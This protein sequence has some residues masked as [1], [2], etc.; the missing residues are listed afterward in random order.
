MEEALFRVWNQYVN[1]D[2]YR[3]TS[4][5]Y[6]PEIK[7]EGLDPKKD[8]FKEKYLEIE[9]LFQI[10]TQLEEKG[11]TYQERWRDGPIT[12]SGII[13]FN[14]TSINNDY[15]DFVADYEQALKFYQR[16]RGGA[17][18]TVV[19]NFTSFLAD[20]KMSTTEKD[21][22]ERLHQWSEEKRSYPNHIITV[23]ASHPAFESA[24][25]L[26]LPKKGQRTTVASP[27]GSFDHF[28]E[29]VKDRIEVYLPYLKGE[30][31]SYLRVGQR[32][33][34]ECIKLFF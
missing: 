15:L 16:W 4:E 33:G 29:E 27:Y 9:Q 31:L 30:E 25:M 13:R 3:V 17:L 24:Q 21:L 26:C 22:V 23:N 34:P 1:R 2:V 12:A 6:L 5:E 11:I 10:M 20:K 7:R 18:S 14:S 32:I 28:K 8:P 19:F